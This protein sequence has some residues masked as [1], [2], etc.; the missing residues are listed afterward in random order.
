MKKLYEYLV[1]VIFFLTVCS[2][3]IYYLATKPVEK[4]SSLEARTLTAFP[5]VTVDDYLSGDFQDKFE[6]AFS[7]QVPKRAGF[8][9]VTAQFNRLF[10][11]LSYSASPQTGYPLAKSTDSPYLY[12][13]KGTQLLVPPPSRYYKNVDDSI[14]KEL[15][16]Y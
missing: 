14:K 2:F 5:T 12:T 1:I 3:S 15:K 13:Y 6:K 8:L 10:S 11:M 4:Q 16:S 9:L 7:D